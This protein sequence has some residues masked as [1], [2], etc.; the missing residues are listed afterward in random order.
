MRAIG[1][2][3]INLGMGLPVLYLAV[4][5]VALHSLSPS[6]VIFV[7]ALSFILVA[8]GREVKV[9]SAQPSNESADA[10]RLVA[11]NASRDTVDDYTHP[12][13]VGSAKRLQPRH[14]PIDP[15]RRIA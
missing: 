5:G 12:S 15:T 14:T 2:E 1:T 7:G 4:A 10:A 8:L 13:N 3:M 6:G 11:S 9:R